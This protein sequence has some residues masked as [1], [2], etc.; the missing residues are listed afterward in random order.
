MTDA[1]VPIS[2]AEFHSRERVVWRSHSRER[3]RKGPT[4]KRGFGPDFQ[5]A[6]SPS[7]FIRLACNTTLW[8][9]HISTN[10]APAPVQ[11]SV[12]KISLCP[13]RMSGAFKSDRV[14]KLVQLL[15][16]TVW[17]FLKKLNLELLCDPGITFLGIYLENM[18]TLIEKKCVNPCVHS[19][20]IYCSQD[21]DAT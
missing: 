19:S 14:C 8:P 3:E 12:C 1:V 5:A 9:L 16:K 6:G 17:R 11:G 10:L 4:R 21:M 7:W 13:G 15:W 20:T 2:R 18:K